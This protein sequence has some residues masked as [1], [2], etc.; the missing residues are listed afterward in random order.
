MDPHRPTTRD[1]AQE[2]GTQREQDYKGDGGYDAMGG[3]ASRGR[4]VVE[5]RPESKP[6]A[7]AVAVVITAAAAAVAR[8]PAARTSTSVTTAAASPTAELGEGWIGERG[9]LNFAFSF[10][11][12]WRG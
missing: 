5:A 12:P 9:W 2:N 7:G 8:V 6:E 4:L 10:C 1:D 3:A 11:T